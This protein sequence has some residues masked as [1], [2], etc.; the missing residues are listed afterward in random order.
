MKS[1]AA[2]LLVLL[3]C[4]TATPVVCARETE[5]ALEA[6]NPFV[7]FFGEWTLKDDKFSQV[8]DGH[9]V[10]TVTIPRHHTECK[11]VNTSQSVMCVVDAGGLKGHIFWA[12]D[13][14]SGQV[15][16]LSHFGD[17][18]LGVGTGGI[19]PGGDLRLT[20][21]FT[22]EPDGTYRVYEYTW[23]TAHEYSMISRQF[24]SKGEATGN[25][26][27]GTFVRLRK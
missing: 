3:S 4:A 26:Y 1:I 25:W 19:S 2:L 9:T 27:G 21:R 11:T 8:W 16:H 20:L 18:R 12:F 7:A 5:K 24:D 13:Q 15:H 22:D 14:T 17:R 23:I 10:E 6:S